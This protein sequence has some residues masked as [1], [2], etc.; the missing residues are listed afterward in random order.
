[1]LC[2]LLIT[3]Y[4]SR[5]T[6]YHFITSTKVCILYQKNK[7]NYKNVVV[8]DYKRSITLLQ[9]VVVQDYTFSVTHWYSYMLYILSISNIILIL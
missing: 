8:Q 7:K 6:T 4:I 1:M 2:L 9:N 3:F 5:L